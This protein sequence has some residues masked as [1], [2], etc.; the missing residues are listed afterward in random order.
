VGWLQYTNAYINDQVSDVYV[1][2][3]TAIDQIYNGG[4]ATIDLVQFIDEC[5]ETY[6][7][8]VAAFARQWMRAY[9]GTALINFEQLDVRINL[10]EMR[11][12]A[13]EAARQYSAGRKFGVG[14]GKP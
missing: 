7:N 12:E 6:I 2:L 1:S 4:D 5:G 13:K 14:R 3:N 10:E 9:L 8:N 11:E